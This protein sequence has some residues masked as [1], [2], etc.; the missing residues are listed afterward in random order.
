MKPKFRIFVRNGR[1]NCVAWNKDA[2]SIIYELSKN[3][4]QYYGIYFVVVDSNQ[5]LK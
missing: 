3:K 4:E 2:S 1:Y 5:I